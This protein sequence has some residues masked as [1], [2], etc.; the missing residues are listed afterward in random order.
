MPPPLH[1]PMIHLSAP[2]IS[3]GLDLRTRQV[4]ASENCG[5][6]LTLTAVARSSS[7]RQYPS[8]ETEDRLMLDQNEEP[9]RAGSDAHHGMDMTDAATATERQACVERLLHPDHL[10]TRSEV[11]GRPCPVPARPGLYA[12]YFNQSPPQVTMA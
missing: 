6:N 11:L 12:W 7:A 5:A 10:Y 3:R 4:N 9:G 8:P 1:S 2:A